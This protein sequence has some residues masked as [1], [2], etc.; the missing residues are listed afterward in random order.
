MG[1]NKTI[2]LC[3]ET[4]IIAERLPN[5]SQ[6]VRYHLKN[7]AR[8]TKKLIQESVHVAIEPARVWGPEK[9]KCNPKHKNGSCVTC[10]GEL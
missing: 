4:A 1:V 6:F 7:H 9:D 5:F 3:P 8:K 10:W 2:S